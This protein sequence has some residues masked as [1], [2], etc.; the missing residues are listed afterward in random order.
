MDR[1]RRGKGADKNRESDRGM[2]LRDISD[3]N[4]NIVSLDMRNL[5]MK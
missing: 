2:G 4:G 3:N 5:K 1:D